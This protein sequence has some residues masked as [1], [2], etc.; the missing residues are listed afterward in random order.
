M[1]C[2]QQFDDFASP[3]LQAHKNAS[4]NGL[5]CLKK[6]CDTD[7]TGNVLSRTTQRDVVVS[8]LESATS[9]LTVKRTRGILLLTKVEYIEHHV[10]TWHGTTAERATQNV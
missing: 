5:H 2:E 3:S 10:D 8:M 6:T 1:L 9:S 7:R 4:N